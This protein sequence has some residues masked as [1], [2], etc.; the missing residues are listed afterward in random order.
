M[1]ATQQPKKTQKQKSTRHKVNCAASWE[2]GEKRKD[3]NRR[4]SDPK[5]NTMPPTGGKQPKM[6]W[7]FHGLG[8]TP[9]MLTALPRGD[10]KPVYESV[11]LKDED[12][13]FFKKVA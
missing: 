10:N 2:R 7:Q 3:R 11:K 9:A 8:V 6:P 5:P 1:E 13:K 12:V 4:P